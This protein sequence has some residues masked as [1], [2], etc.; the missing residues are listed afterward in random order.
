MEAYTMDK[1]RRRIR[2]ASIDRLT[3]NSDTLRVRRLGPWSGTTN[4][5][6]AFYTRLTDHGFVPVHPRERRGSELG[7]LLNRAENLFI[8]CYAS[9]I[10]FICETD[11]PFCPIHAIVERTCAAE[12]AL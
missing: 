3:F 5:P 7:W 8:T 12:V 4:D 1:P 9:G 6:T 2:P 11:T 10:F